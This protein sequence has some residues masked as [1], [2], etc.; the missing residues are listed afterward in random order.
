MQ[1]SQ[2]TLGL[3]ASTVERLCLESPRKPPQE[4]VY[5]EAGK[6][7]GL[8]LKSQGNANL[9]EREREEVVGRS[10]TVFIPEVLGFC[11]PESLGLSP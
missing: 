8:T 6:P 3:S 11:L 10:G 1:C 9:K 2:S 5:M 7:H 4:R